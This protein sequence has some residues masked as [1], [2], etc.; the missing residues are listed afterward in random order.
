MFS[1]KIIH[2]KMANILKN[3]LF[4]AVAGLFLMTFA[5]QV[6]ALESKANLKGEVVSV[7]DYARTVT[8]RSLE[9]VPISGI[10]MKDS[11]TFQTDKG[12]NVTSCTQNKA[13]N[14]INVG[15]KV[16]V[17]YHELDGKRF[18]DVIDISPVVLAYAC[19]DE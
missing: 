12:T 14:D 1:R 11:I 2:K 16:T 5:T 13:F 6:N 9:T 10:G 8:V 3:V 15:E 17:T 19:L 18:A 7:D 4:V